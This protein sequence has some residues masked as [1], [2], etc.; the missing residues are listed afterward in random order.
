MKLKMKLKRINEA[1]EEN[2]DIY[3]FLFVPTLEPYSKQVRL[4]IRCED[5]YETMGK[6]KLPQSVGDNIILEMIHKEE[7]TKLTDKTK[8]RSK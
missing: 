4:F 2:K 1:R 5:P 6:L 3:T 8:T 7:Q